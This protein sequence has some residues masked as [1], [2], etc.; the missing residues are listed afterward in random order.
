MESA[1]RRRRVAPQEAPADEGLEVARTRGP[2]D[3]YARARERAA[4]GED[5]ERL[6]QLPLASLSRA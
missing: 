1:R 6:V 3:E 4:A 5:R 2:V